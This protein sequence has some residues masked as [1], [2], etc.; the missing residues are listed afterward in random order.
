MCFR[1][2]V[3]IV[4]FSSILAATG[5]SAQVVGPLH[6]RPELFKGLVACRAMQDAAARLACFDTA[7]ASLDDAER[8]GDIVMID[9]A[10]ASAARRQMFG[11]D[12][13]SMSD[14]FGRGDDAEPISEIQTTLVRASSAGGGSWVF[15]LA[16][17]TTW[18]QINST[19]V[20]VSDRAGQNVRIRR[21]AVGSYL[22]TVG[23]SQ[24]MRV[25]RV[26]P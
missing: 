8:D 18:R 10:R 14:L 4:F 23:N 6:D 20:R 19:P 15:A 17:G 2:I 12:L 24:A 13:P 11:I 7:V 26:T 16:D 3:S 5:S 21:G 22:L 9:R 1:N 25:R